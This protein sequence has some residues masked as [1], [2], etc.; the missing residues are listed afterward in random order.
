VLIPHR[1]PLL[2]A[3]FLARYDR[4]IAELDLEGRTVEAHCVNPGRMEGLVRRGA[5]AWIS[6]AP[7]GSRRRLRYTLELLE[8]DGRFIGANTVEPNRLVEILLRERAID[9]LRRFRS[10]R[11]EVPYGGHSRIDFLLDT[12][13]GEHLVEVKNCHLVYPDDCAYF[14]DSV[15]ARAAGHLKALADEVR[16]G[17]RASVLFM[18]QHSDGHRLRPSR[19]HDPVFSEAAGDAAAAGVRFRAVRVDPRP[20]GF[21]FQGSIPVDLRPYDPQR[22]APWR[23]A[24]VDSS[25]WRRRGAR[26]T[27]N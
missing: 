22:L 26:R 15:S 2:E 23:E 10:L 20:E 16:A 6:E 8:I 12:A 9:G 11:R 24:L 3:T 14:P 21:L 25:G 4:F 7:P 13:S 19:L 17:R 1:L 27:A 5:R 18:L